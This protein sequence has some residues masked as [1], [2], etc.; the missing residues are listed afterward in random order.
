MKGSVCPRLNKCNKN[1]KVLKKNKRERKPL[2]ELIED[3]DYRRPPDNAKYF[4]AV[5]AL[6]KRA[7][8]KVLAVMDDES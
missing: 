6:K 5:M 4:N 7:H 8:C 3:G 1:L 2:L